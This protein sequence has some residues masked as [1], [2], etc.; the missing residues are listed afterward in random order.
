MPCPKKFPE[1]P[2]FEKNITLAASYSKIS[3]VSSLRNFKRKHVFLHAISK[4]INYYLKTVVARSS[5]TLSKL[6]IQVI[7]FQE[8]SF[9][10][11][12]KLDK[13]VQFRLILQ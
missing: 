6:V 11:G 7:V 1:F 4:I 9:F 13:S 3:E 8:T 10:D 12:R 2:D 5:A